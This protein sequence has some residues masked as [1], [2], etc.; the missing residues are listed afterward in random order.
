MLVQSGD[1]RHS[2]STPLNTSVTVF[3]TSNEATDCSLDEDV[4]IDDDSNKEN[5]SPYRAPKKLSPPCA[6]IK[7]IRR[8]QTGTEWQSVLDVIKHGEEIWSKQNDAVIEE[9]KAC[10]AVSRASFRP[11]LGGSFACCEAVHYDG[12][13][14]IDC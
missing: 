7:R 5:I 3:C 14:L 11:L 2:K 6:S 1:K 9:M 13:D 8:E 12:H 10:T 4:G